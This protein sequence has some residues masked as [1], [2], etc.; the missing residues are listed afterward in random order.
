[1][2]NRITNSQEI[3]EKMHNKE[4]PLCFA[5]GDSRNK[6]RKLFAT[7]VQYLYFMENLKDY[8]TE[9]TEMAFS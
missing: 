8:P 6:K 1:M 3:M 5:N 4:Y 7:G 9:Q 2:E